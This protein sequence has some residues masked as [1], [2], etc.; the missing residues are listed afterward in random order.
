MST[1]G[2]PFDAELVS[3]ELEQSSEERKEEIADSVFHMLSV[4]PSKDTSDV[5]DLL[6]MKGFLEEEESESKRPGTRALKE[7]R[8]LDEEKDDELMSRLSLDE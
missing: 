4:Q 2:L 8:D 1:A 5:P 3:R 6:D 7:S